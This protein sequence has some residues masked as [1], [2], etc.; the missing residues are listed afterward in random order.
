MRR[1][2]LAV[3]S[4][5]LFASLLVVMGASPASATV[6]SFTRE[7]GH[8]RTSTD[9]GTVGAL[10]G[11]SAT[12]DCDHNPAQTTHRWQFRVMSSA[13]VSDVSVVF[14]A[15]QFGNTPVGNTTVSKGSSMFSP[16]P[17]GIGGTWY[18]V[19]TVN[20]DCTGDG[21]AVVRVTS[22]SDTRNLII[23]IDC[24]ATVTVTVADDSGI[25]TTYGA[26]RTNRAQQIGS[27]AFT[28]GGSVGAMATCSATPTVRSGASVAGTLAAAVTGSGASRRVSFTLSGA[29]AAGRKQWNVRVNCAWQ[30]N[31]GSDT[32]IVTVGVSALVGR[33]SAAGLELAPPEQEPGDTWVDTFST[34]ALPSAASCS[35]SD[36]NSATTITLTNGAT[37]NSISRTHTLSVHSAVETTASVTVRCTQGTNTPYSAVVNIEWND[38]APG[39]SINGYDSQEA[40][41]EGRQSVTATRAFTVRPAAAVCSVV[42]TGGTLNITPS[43]DRTQSD[44]TDVSG[45]S[46]RGVDVVST[47]TGTVNTR[48]TCTHSGESVSDTNTFT[49]TDTGTPTMSPVLIFDLNSAPD[50][51]LTNRHENTFRTD[52][53]NA[54]CTLGATSGPTTS[55]PATW[56]LRNSGRT[57]RVDSAI[58]GDTNG[59]VVCSATGR[60]TTI[61]RVSITFAADDDDNPPVTADDTVTINGLEENPATVNVGTTYNRGFSTVPSSTTTVTCTATKA[62]GEGTFT[63][64]SARNLRVTA[65]ASNDITGFVDCSA[66]GYE[67]GTVFVTVPFRHANENQ[68]NSIANGYEFL[69]GKGF[70]ETEI[71]VY[72]TNDGTPATEVCGDHTNSDP[73]F[74]YSCF[75]YG[76]NVFDQRAYSTSCSVTRRGGPG[77][78]TYTISGPRA[79][80]YDS[81]DGGRDIFT[82]EGY[83]RTARATATGE[84]VFRVTCGSGNSRS[85]F[86]VTVNAVSIDAPADEI[87]GFDDASGRLTGGRATA[88]DDITVS[89]SSLT[90]TA[91][92]VGGSLDI[93]PRVT[94]SGSTRT[95]SA[96]STLEG[97]LSV[98]VDCGTAAATATFRFLSDAHTIR[99]L[100][101]ASARVVNGSGTASDDFIVS[102]GSL[103]CDASRTGGTLNVQPQVTGSGTS[104]TVSATA[105]EAGTVVFTVTCGAEEVRGVTFTFTEPEGPTAQIT[106]F[107]SQSKP[108]SGRS[109][110]ISVP[111]TF[112]PANVSCRV[113][114]TGGSLRGTVV[115]RTDFHQN[116]GVYFF[117]IATST[118]AG[119][120]EMELTCGDA[121]ATATFRWTAPGTEQVTISRLTSADATL[122]GSRASITVPVVVV[123]ENTRCDVTRTGGSIPSI[124]PEF[125]THVNGGV[126]H[127]VTL[128]AVSP[129]TVDFDLECGGATASATFTFRPAPLPVTTITGLAPRTAIIRSGYATALSTFTV[130]PY[131]ECTVTVNG[132]TLQGTV[133]PQITGFVN[134]GVHPYVEARSATTGDI[135]F[136]IQ[137][138]SAQ[139]TTTFSFER[140]PSAD[141]T[142]TGLSDREGEEGDRLI[143]S[144][145]VTPYTECATQIT[146]GTLRGT[147]T[148]QVNAFQ[149]GGIHPYVEARS[150]A[151]GTLAFRVICGGNVASAEFEW[152]AGP[153]PP[154]PDIAQGIS[155]RSGTVGDRLE[156][157]FRVT[158]V[159]V[160][161]TAARTSGTIAAG[162]LTVTIGAYQNGG[163]FPFVRVTSTAAGNA[164]V[165]LT[166]GSDTDTAVFT[167]AAAPVGTA[168]SPDIA[169]GISDRSG[170]VGDR[171]ESFFRVTPVDV[172]CTA[173]RTAGSLDSEVSVTIGAYQNGGYFPFVRVTSTAAGD[174]TVTLTCG[175]DTDTAVFTF[176][177]APVGTARNPDIASG[178]SD[179]SGVVGDRLESFFRVTPVDVNCTAARTAGSL[180]SEVSVTIGAY[181][182][183]GYF[184]FV[185]VTSTAAGDATVTLTCGSDTDTAVFT[186]AAA[187]VGTV[188]NP[189]IASGISDRSGVVG[190]RLESFFRVT[191]VDTNCTA[192]RTDGSLDSE[193]T[194]TIG[195]YQ[196]GGYFPFVRVTS[197]AAG[198]ATVTLTCGSDT[199]TAVFTFAASPT[200]AAVVIHGL[201]DPRG[202]LGDRLHATFSTTPS[203]AAADCTVAY[204]SGETVTPEIGEFVSF[205]PVSGNMVI[206]NVNA[207]HA[208]T[209][210]AAMTATL[211]CGTTRET[212]TF[213]WSPAR[214][215]VT[216]HG[217]GDRRGVAGDQLL[218]LFYTMPAS[219]AADCT[220]VRT[221]GIN[222]DPWFSST[223]SVTPFGVSISIGVAAEH[224]GSTQ[225]TMTATLTCGTDTETV[226]FSWSAAGTTANPIIHGLADQLGIAGTTLLSL[227]YT[228]PREAAADCTVA[229]TSGLSETPRITVRT[230]SSPQ[231]TSV[232]IGVEA[233]SLNAAGGSMVATLTCGAATELVAF[234][235]SVTPMLN[236]VLT[237]GTASGSPNDELLL[238]YTTNPARDAVSCRA[239][240][241][242]SG[243]DG[244]LSAAVTPQIQVIGRTDPLTVVAAFSATAGHLNATLTCGTAPN[245]YTATLEFSWVAFTGDDDDPDDE[246]DTAAPNLAITG[247]RAT[248]AG[249]L[250]SGTLTLTDTFT[251]TPLEADCSYASSSPRVTVSLTYDS[252]DEEHTLSVTFTLRMAVQLRVSCSATGYDSGSQRVTWRAEAGT[253]NLADPPD[254]PCL[255]NGVPFTPPRHAD[256]VID[257]RVGGAYLDDDTPQG[258][259]S[260]G[261]SVPGEIVQAAANEMEV[262][263]GPLRITRINCV[264]LINVG[265]HGYEYYVIRPTGAECIWT[266]QSS[267]AVRAW[268]IPENLK[269]AYSTTGSSRYLRMLAKEEGAWAI[270]GACTATVI[271]ADGFPGSHNF[272]I[273]LQVNAVT[274]DT[275]APIIGAV[276]L[277]EFGGFGEGNEEW[278]FG[279]AWNRLV[280][281][282]DTA[283][284]Y[285][286]AYRAALDAHADLLRSIGVSASYVAYTPEQVFRRHQALIDGTATPTESERAFTGTRLALTP[287]QKLEIRESDQ[288]LIDA[289]ESYTDITTDSESFWSNLGTGLRQVWTA[290]KDQPRA[291]ACIALRL[292]LPEPRDISNVITSAMGSRGE[293]CDPDRRGPIE[294]CDEGGLLLW[295]IEAIAQAQADPDCRGPYVPVGSALSIVTGVGQ[296]SAAG[297]DPTATA[298]DADH[299][300]SE[301][302][303]PAELRG[304][305]DNYYFSV[306]DNTDADDAAYDGDL[307]D[308]QLHALGHTPG[309]PGGPT[310]FSDL[311]TSQLASIGVYLPTHGIWAT[312]WNN[313]PLALAINA[314]LV[315]LCAFTLFRLV[316]AL[317]LTISGEEQ[318][319][320][321]AGGGTVYYNQPPRRPGIGTGYGELGP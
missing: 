207:V 146:G 315:L 71:Y 64:S 47:A 248:H 247:L 243:E 308:E 233:T 8:S 249:A 235:W 14:N 26:A 155:D 172:N 4:T 86:D 15:D 171:L 284:A 25:A 150:D 183:G 196:N 219:A 312:L 37:S 92:D 288:R 265:I 30:G 106:S 202:T 36:S 33:V 161:C 275:A 232:S 110:T 303:T 80:A 45:G 298:D 130:A 19:L 83:A 192:A 310:K 27:V 258:G 163:Y 108:L 301:L 24:D 43:V 102:P 266:V 238:G 46:V 81:T 70:T 107:P 9:C 201:R 77:T 1:S 52:P 286:D 237:T 11:N 154:P 143:S 282:F 97:T 234:T 220:V 186:F 141:H 78:I 68:G 190:D 273:T 53:T 23:D 152:T 177:A 254:A 185:R 75:E 136:T 216:I 55:D 2:V 131:T 90:C 65:T 139:A 54:Q 174:A 35:A 215:T 115:P 228:T 96:T 206:Y 224:T 99:S 252:D 62:T 145:T 89:P 180:D 56:S 182:N 87:T 168:D 162:D 34:V 300:P 49:F 79:I 259:V 128:S 159:D 296:T 85:W 251:T 290:I 5:L 138:G 199:D 264:I 160:N 76:R 176:A 217:L 95:V 119:D 236:T 121:T 98:R 38:D 278:G 274:T 289:Q 153:S 316:R 184:P 149:N 42:R 175:S 6:S 255:I 134:G 157:F 307:T 261:F 167:F 306:C 194:V 285:K 209:T 132:G 156:S 263:S 100:A 223:R 229:Y 29:T 116:G 311:S 187:P 13:S 31:S 3:L 114:A 227:F 188:R 299:L 314:L 270:S 148:P 133:T 277:P 124:T 304:Q 135:R 164:T 321:A 317:I 63:L 257:V 94:G 51:V 142:I 245:T 276:D 73:S 193:V 101:D 241:T 230:V 269:L 292:L 293:G 118:R 147:V 117:V 242:A 61:I 122:H 67:T 253:V 50:D 281:C 208:G 20:P 272:A 166:C 12:V 294:A 28:V 240:A 7:P 18:T 74:R 189:D 250:S 123:P 48:V 225:A 218:S 40:D 22:G 178:I 291:W 212:V 126:Y 60:A 44:G 16:G 59:Q 313:R 32:T 103:T 256:S 120:L 105:T 195:A 72:G 203:S 305:F 39:V 267:S 170:T 320:A 93:T 137:C 179:R 262:R 84:A 158:P 214:S 268:S 297:G 211:T 244:D 144:F 198:N 151:A 17:L 302:L 221:S 280:S 140:E 91:S 112:E 197:T 113:A 82:H 239:V 271:D 210:A 226:T 200:S 287:A 58:D 319:V 127:F 181:Q 213:S 205:D 295:P 125:R 88:S 173:A 169:S 111:Y 109:T 204:T 41:L 10:R 66:D 222:T 283:E 246:E 309:E 231:G 165:T 129:G 279:Y 318:A 191:P 260:V 57:L 104:R 69:G 21:D